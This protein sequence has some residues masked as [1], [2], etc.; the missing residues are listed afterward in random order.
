ML[1]AGALAVSS[2]GVMLLPAGAEAAVPGA[3]AGATGALTAASGADATGCGGATG[4]WDVFSTTIDFVAEYSL[5]AGVAATFF[6]ET[7]DGG[8][9]GTISRVNIGA[10]MGRSTEGSCQ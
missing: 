7:G 3:D 4:A 1:L 10:V 5:L 2:S 9:V 8:A 6:S